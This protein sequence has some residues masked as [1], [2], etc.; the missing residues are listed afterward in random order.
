MTVTGVLW[1]MALVIVIAA[2]EIWRVLRDIRN[3]LQAITGD[4]YLPDGKL[5]ALAGRLD[6]VVSELD[7][8][9]GILGGILASVP[10]PPSE[11]ELRSDW[12]R[13]RRQLG[14]KN[15]DTK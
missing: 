7:R 6:A 2:Y 1:A 3:S 12:D 4:R 8:I 9:G 11:P 14:V 13:L 15:Q 5:D 10:S